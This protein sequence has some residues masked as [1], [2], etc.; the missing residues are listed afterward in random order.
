MTKIIITILILLPSIVSAATTGLSKAKFNVN[1]QS[2]EVITQEVW[3]ENT[4]SIEQKY[5]FR[6]DDNQ[7]AQSVSIIPQKFI[8]FLIPRPLAAGTPALYDAGV[9]N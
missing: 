9:W 6:I 4:D 5:E 7:F 1:A 2:G 3:I 8:I